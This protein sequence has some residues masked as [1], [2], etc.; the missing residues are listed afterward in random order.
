LEA[1]ERSVALD[2]N[3]A[4]TL[5]LLGNSYLSMGRFPEALD[6]FGR[7]YDHGNRSTDLSTG[8]ESGSQLG[9]ERAMRTLREL[10]AGEKNHAPAMNLLGYLLAE[11]GSDLDEAERLVARALELRPENPFF[12]DS[13]GWIYFKKGEAGRAVRELEQAHAA[14]REDPTILEHLADAYAAAGRRE[15]AIRARE[16]LRLKEPRPAAS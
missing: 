9:R 12:R 3:N 1:L 8:S 6:L 13:L 14:R 11:R 2:P 7:A 15:D 16:V 5:F 10:L 4:G